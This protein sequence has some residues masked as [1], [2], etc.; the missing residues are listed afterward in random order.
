M[1]ARL[2]ADF[3]DV[4]IHTDV[5]A[6][7]SASALSARA[8]T[9]GNEVVFGDGAFA[10]DTAAGRHT[11]A[12][13]LTHVQQQRAGAVSGRDAGGGIALSDPADSFEQQA[14][15]AAHRALTG[16]SGRGGAEQTP[17]TTTLAS[18][19]AGTSPVRGRP[20]VQ[21]ECLYGS[22]YLQPANMKT[23]AEQIAG[24]K[25]GVPAGDKWFPASEDFKETAAG[26]P[27]A[28]NL[29][30][31]VAF[32]TAKGAGSVT[33][34]KII[35]HA[36]G[37]DGGRLGLA[38]RIDGPHNANVWFDAAG[39]IDKTSAAS[40]APFKDRFA[41][42]GSVTLVGCD[43]ATGDDLMTALATALGV[44]VNGYT[45]EIGWCL[46]N[47]GKKVTGRGKTGKL[48]TDPLGEIVFTGCGP[49]PSPDKSKC[50][51][52]PTPTPP[53]VQTPPPAAPR[54]S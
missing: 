11:L 29:T 53:P 9:V 32:L 46:N 54:Q 37:S 52:A 26:G 7:R 13:E 18:A 25:S 41:K 49:I 43:S 45:V 17:S 4:R 27:G 19:R 24:S 15:A 36:D 31:L 33:D 10:P 8:Y 47:D 28:K 38:G 3:S 14:E 35:G 2:G 30:E 6:A 48:I 22:G 20:V 44:C 34:L 51:P 40:L 16:P 42:G 50:P 21:R 1:G 12:H 5:Q 23:D 39:V